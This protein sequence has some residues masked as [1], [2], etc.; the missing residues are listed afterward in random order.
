MS[1]IRLYISV[2]SCRE[3]KSGFNASFL[4]LTAYLLKSGIKNH[5]LQAIFPEIAAQASCLSQARQS[6]LTK[7]INENCTHWLSLDDDM[8]FPGNLVDLMLA[9]DAP[10]VTAN[11]RRKNFHRVVGVCM[12]IDG[13]L[14]DSTGRTGTEK[15]GWMGGGMF[16][17]DI[18]KIKHIPAP[19]FEVV[20]CPERH[21]YYDQD[22][23]F[24][25]KLRQNGI[26]IL[27][28]HDL[29]QKITHIGDYPYSWPEPTF[30]TSFFNMEKL[31][32]PDE[33]A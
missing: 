24:S 33:A 14:I 11:Y 13:E 3:P 28:D 31:Q 1:D 12:G 19:H 29:S 9:H 5:N 18:A 27:L 20:W 25:A 23:Y 21:D 26:D 22:N 6:A 7:A 4:S 2:P 15:I 16:M 30:A 10:V 32:I 17:A 8:M